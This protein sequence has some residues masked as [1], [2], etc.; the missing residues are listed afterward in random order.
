MFIARTPVQRACALYVGRARRTASR[1][2]QIGA[3]GWVGES[4]CMH[5]KRDPKLEPKPQQHKQHKQQ[6]T[7][8]QKQEQ[9]P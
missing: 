7:Q 4:W 5:V 8:K 3:T 9:K 1:D 2:D 6:H